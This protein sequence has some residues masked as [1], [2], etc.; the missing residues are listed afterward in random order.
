MRVLARAARAVTE[1]ES[2]VSVGADA[3][4]GHGSR[5]TTPVRRRQRFSNWQLM[6]LG[7]KAFVSLVILSLRTLTGAPERT[8]RAPKGT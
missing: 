6:C 7:T 3:N 4:S 5:L 2:S 1:A 8:I